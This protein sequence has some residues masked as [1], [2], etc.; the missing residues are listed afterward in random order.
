MSYDYLTLTEHRK[1]VNSYLKFT[2]DK[3]RFSGINI[4]SFSAIKVFTE[5]LSHCLGHKYSLFITIKE[6]HL[7]S[8]KNFHSTLENHE[9]RESLAQWIFPRL[10]YSKQIT[11]K[12][13]FSRATN[14]KEFMDFLGLSQN[15]FHWKLLEFYCDM[16]F[17]LK[18]SLLFS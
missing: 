4:C 12:C 8:W 5:I 13:L 16:D 11:I 18:R 15:F 10:W 2:I 7:Y 9:K 14:F 1:V 6:R 17:R 3:E